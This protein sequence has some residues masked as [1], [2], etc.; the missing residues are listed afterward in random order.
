MSAERSVTDLEDGLELVEKDL[1]RAFWLAVGWLALLVV[2]AFFADW[3]P[4]DDPHEIG[5]G[6]PRE[7]PSPDHLFGTDALG[8]DVFS[9]TI[10]GA[11]ISLLVGFLAILFGIIVG[12]GLGI[13]AGYFRGLVDQV[14]SFSFF[15]LLSFP[16][17]VLALLITALIDRNQLTV[18][19]T[20]GILSIAPVGRLARANT[21]VFAEREFV[22]AARVLGA[23]SKRII[24]REILPNVMIPMS[25]LALLGMGIAIVAE[26]S[27]AFLGLSV[28][29]DAVSWGKSIVDGSQARDLEQNPNVALFPIGIMFLTV[30]ALNYAGD[31]VREYFDVR[32]TAF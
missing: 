29:G 15:T 27:L 17:L 4:I 19:L 32:E 31:R 5:A 1:G 7:G 25:A 6:G 10:F 30:L 14:I 28:E 13:V 20:L 2:L 16:G 22:Q 24:V 12:G 26:G 21:I 18:S 23:D 9:R 11:R 8:R 3:L